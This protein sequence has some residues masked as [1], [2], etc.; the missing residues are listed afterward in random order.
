V[1]YSYATNLVPGATSDRSKVYV[2]NRETKETELISIDSAGNIN[3]DHAGFPRISAKGRFVAF[4]SLASNLVEEDT[5][6]ESDIFIHDLQTKITERVSISSQGDQADARSYHAWLSDDGRFVTFHSYASNFDDN[7]TNDA[8][9]IFV[10]DRHK[11]ITT[12]VNIPEDK[13]EG[14]CSSVYGMIS[15]NA[16]SIVFCSC[17]SNLITGDTNGFYDVFVMKNPLFEE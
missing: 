15:A 8:Q 13:E 11:R 4:H 1:F 14:N 2:H 5:N 6:G 3:N 10:H 12:R 17:A 16:K 7:T 9:D